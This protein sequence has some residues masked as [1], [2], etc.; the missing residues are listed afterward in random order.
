MTQKENM[1]NIKKLVAS[2]T[3]GDFFYLYYFWWEIGNVEERQYLLKSAKPILFCS[4]EPAVCTSQT[5][6]RL[7]EAIKVAYWNFEEQRKMSTTIYSCDLVKKLDD[8]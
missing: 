4:A 2:M 7:R 6:H 3:K 5:G 1:E 8:E